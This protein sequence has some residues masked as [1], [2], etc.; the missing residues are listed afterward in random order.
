[1]HPEDVLLLEKRTQDLP[2]FLK[3]ESACLLEILTGIGVPDPHFAVQR[4]W[5]V[6]DL[7]AK[8][9]SQQ[10][11]DVSTRGR[12]LARTAFFM[13]TYLAQK[14]SSAWVVMKDEDSESFGRYVVI[15]SASR[16]GKSMIAD[17]FQVAKDVITSD[18]P[19]KSFLE[20]ISALDEQMRVFAAP[21]K[22]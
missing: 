14:Y 20:S 3:E 19:S 2:I 22:N 17:V 18:S 9:L 16:G 7:F 21:D 6:V 8:W 10:K 4:V 1:M 5:S 12:L 15:T 11:V 13:G